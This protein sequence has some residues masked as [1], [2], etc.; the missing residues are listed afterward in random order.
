MNIKTA[1][2]QNSIVI[3]LRYFT[4]IILK[5]RLHYY[6]CTFYKIPLINIEIAGSELQS[7]ICRSLASN[8]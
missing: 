5:G 8:T 2:F 1:I 3:L 7:T 6:C 4:T